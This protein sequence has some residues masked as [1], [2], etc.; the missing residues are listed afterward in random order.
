[1][2]LSQVDELVDMSLWTTYVLKRPEK[3]VCYL[4][5][6][7]AIQDR[8]DVHLQLFNA[9]ALRGVYLWDEFEHRLEVV[10]NNLHRFDSMCT[11]FQLPQGK[12]WRGQPGTVLVFCEQGLGEV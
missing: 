12:I 1:M 4:R 8:A 5:R 9:Q 3:A 2:E 6:A 7:L 11:Y 10:K